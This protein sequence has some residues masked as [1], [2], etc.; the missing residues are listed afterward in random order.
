MI[1]A[2]SRL[3]PLRTAPS[4]QHWD[5]GADETME[6]HWK[7]GAVRNGFKRET[8]EII[9]EDVLKFA[10][11]A[12]NKSHSAGYAILVMQTAWLKAHYPHEYMAAVLTSFMGKVTR[13]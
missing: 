10:S 12:F 5:D 9:W 4:F 2:V 1:S 3:K 8:A 6:Q 11:Y 13:F 7:E